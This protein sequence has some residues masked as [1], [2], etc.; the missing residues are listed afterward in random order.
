LLVQSVYSL[1][2]VGGGYYDAQIEERSALR[3]HAHIDAAQGIED[4]RGH[5]RSISDILAHQANDR[6]VLLDLDFGELAHLGADHLQVLRVVD[7]QRNADLGGGDHVDGRFEAVEDFEDA[8]QESVR[9]QHARGVDVDQRDFA[10]AGDR[11]HGVAAM[12]LPA[13]DAGAVDLRA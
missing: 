9:H 12:H 5:S 4:A 2:E 8:A 6:L 1:N 10:F 13:G 3:D 11:L 7:G